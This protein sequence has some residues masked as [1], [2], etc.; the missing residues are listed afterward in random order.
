MNIAFYAPLKPIDHPVPSGDRAIA[1]ALQ[2]ALRLAGHR[3]SVASRLRSFD[4]RGDAQRQAR[5]ARIGGCIAQRLVARWRRSDAPQLWFTYHL[6]H[7]APDHVGLPASRALGIPYVVAEASIAPSQRDGPW[8]LGYEAAYE[9]IIAADNVVFVN[10]ADVPEVRK[11]RGL[12]APFALLAPFVDTTCFGGAARRARLAPPRP[13]RIVTVAMMREGAKLAS[14]RL[15]ADA[16]VRLG[17]TEFFL[18]IVGDGPAR[19][20]VEAAFAPLAPRVAFAGALAP[21]AIAAQLL[22]GDLFA[23]PAIDEAI[24]IAFLEAQA[25]GVPVV[26]ADT[27]GVAGIVAA[28]RT[29]ILVAPG[30]PGA[31]AGALRRMLGDAAL[32]ERMGAEAF[33]HVRAHHDVS[34][35]AR[36]LD[37]ILQDTLA[38]NRRADAATVPC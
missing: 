28:G 26:G 35:A 1:N 17:D 29:G 38:R 6:H 33:A 34:S 10:P 32:R 7:K 27:P 20:A 16:L 5:L 3:V 18:T 25:C 11:A 31:F 21:A 19:P 2:D 8:A 4:A 24:G 30:D 13:L 14:Y 9:A 22:A 23:W 37:A 15:L 36:Q 12:A